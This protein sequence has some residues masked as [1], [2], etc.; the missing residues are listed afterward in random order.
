MFRKL[1]SDSLTCSSNVS[2][3]AKVRDFVLLSRTAFLLAGLSGGENS[4]L[5]VVFSS[6]ERPVERSS[7]SSKSLSKTTSLTRLSDESDI[8]SESRISSICY[9][10]LMTL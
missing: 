2:D 10:D 3:A 7:E 5:G 1:T 8:F 9:G 4:E 6:V